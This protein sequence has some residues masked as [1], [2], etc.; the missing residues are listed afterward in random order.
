MKSALL[1]FL[2]GGIG[3]LIR[4]AMGRWIGPMTTYPFPLATLIINILACLVLGFV[5]G[6]ADHRQVISPSARLFWTVGV[7]GGFSTFSTFSNETLFLLQSGFNL[8]FILYITLSVALCLG[9]TFGGMYL[10]GRV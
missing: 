6:L 1:V 4:Y 2:G 9:A 3:S 8:S 10:S 5:I 7:C